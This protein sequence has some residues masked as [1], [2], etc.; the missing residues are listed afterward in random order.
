MHLS[1]TLGLSECATKFQVLCICDK[2]MTDVWV[3]QYM[4]PLRVYATHLHHLPLLPAH[5][6]PHATPPRLTSPH[7][8]HPNLNTLILP[9]D[10]Q[11][12]YRMCL[13][14]W[15]EQDLE[16][17]GSDNTMLLGRP[18]PGGLLGQNS[19]PRRCVDAAFEL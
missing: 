7:A 9:E 3:T 15:R 4:F 14:K 5:P 10:D 6:T 12:M 17:A 18:G 19:L 1:T 2:A 11:D 16:G 8:L 13:S